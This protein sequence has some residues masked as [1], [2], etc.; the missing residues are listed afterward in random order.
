VRRFIR[1]S[2]GT[3]TDDEEILQDALITA[4]LKVERGDY[5]YRQVPFT[6]F[7]KKIAW[8]KILEAA[9]QY[10][11]HVTLD[12]VI[13]YADDDE[14][15]IT[16]RVEF[17]REYEALKYALSELPARRSKV[18][19]LYENGYSTA[20]IAEHLSIREDLVRKE[21]SLGLRQLRDHM[22]LAIAN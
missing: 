10:P 9:R 2:N 21:K 12:D 16:E 8:Y 13:E 15:A 5:E 22:S 14:G 3:S 11:R 18:L 20:E 4:Y 1:W 17:W 6:A 7:V 19:L